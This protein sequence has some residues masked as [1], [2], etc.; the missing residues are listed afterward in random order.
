MRGGQDVCRPPTPFPP[1]PRRGRHGGPARRC[2]SRRR[3]ARR[4][5]ARLVG[6]GP[7]RLPVRPA[8]RRVHGGSGRRGPGRVRGAG[9]GREL[10]PV[11][12]RRGRGRHRLAA[13]RG[14]RPAAGLAARRRGGAGRGPAAVPRRRGLRP[15][16]RRPALRRL[17]ARAAVLPPAVRVLRLRRGALDDA[18]AARGAVQHAAPVRPGRP[19]LQ[20]RRARMATGHHRRRSPAP[21]RAAAGA[22]P[23]RAAAPRWPDADH[24]LLRHPAGGRAD[25]SGRCRRPAV[26]GRRRRAAAGRAG[27]G[28]RGRARRR[29]A[30]PGRGLRRGRRPLPLGARGAPALGPHRGGAGPDHGAGPRV[31]R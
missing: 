12:L 29:P 13:R 31:L 16:R 17:Q 10:R 7:H 6:G 8:G 11:V 20:G 19:A 26:A 21:G 1:D 22:H 5:D 2:G 28:D 18:G 25:R 23:P 27:R 15:G 30:A 9:R 3:D 4:R 24:D 14:E